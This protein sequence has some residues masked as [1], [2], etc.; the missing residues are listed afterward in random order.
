MS[1]YFGGALLVEGP[2][3]IEQSLITKWSTV[4]I[5]I[6][7]SVNSFDIFNGFG[8]SLV[9][10]SFE[11]FFSLSPVGIFINT[12]RIVACSFDIH[13]NLLFFAPLKYYNLKI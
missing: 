8:S 2:T 13:Y 4:K 7:W 1:Q 12:I 5:G 3:S 9:S 11:L 6:W 10:V